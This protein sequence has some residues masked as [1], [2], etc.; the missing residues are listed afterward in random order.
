MDHVLGIDGGGSK[1]DAVLMDEQGTV[2]GWGRG[3]STHGLY[4][5]ADAAGRSVRDAVRGALTDRPRSAGDTRPTLARLAGT[6]LHA[7][8]AQ[9]IESQG[10]AAGRPSMD[11]FLPAGEQ[12]LGLATAL[13]THGLLVLSGTGSFAYGLTVDGRSRHEGG[14]GPIIADEGSAYHI[15]ILGIRAAFRSRYSAPRH[16]SLAEAVPRAM[17]VKGLGE[18]FQLLYVERIGRS[19]IAA[20]ARTVNEQAEAGD[21]VAAAILRRAADELGELLVEVIHELS[22]EDSDEALVATG[23]VA[24]GSRLFWGRLCEIALAVAPRLRPVQPRV[25]PVIGACLLALRDLGASWNEALVDRI[26]TTQQPFLERLE[27]GNRG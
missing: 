14:Q 24:Q 21:A 13:T 5:G 4:V 16:T 26:V 7:D 9:W 10:L 22:L 23:G 3:G 8:L 11:Q 27:A 25:R 6:G 19:Q 12:A 20:V 18:V 15:G 2:L 1:C 17:G